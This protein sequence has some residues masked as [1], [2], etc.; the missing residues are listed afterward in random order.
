MAQAILI[1]L[2]PIHLRVD[3]VDVCIEETGSRFD[4][5]VVR[6]NPRP[7]RRPRRKPGIYRRCRRIVG[8]AADSPRLMATIQR[9]LPGDAA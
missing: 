8:I 6:L 4:A 9:M 7:V 5:C 3:A 1:S 2:T